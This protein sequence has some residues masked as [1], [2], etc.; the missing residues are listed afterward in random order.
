VFRA[1]FALNAALLLMIMVEVSEAYILA[2]ELK[3]SIDFA[4]RQI[5]NQRPTKSAVFR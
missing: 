1:F 5:E 3:V 4:K 2:R